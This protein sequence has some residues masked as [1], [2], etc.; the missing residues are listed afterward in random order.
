MPMNVSDGWPANWKQGQK[1]MQEYQK[2]GGIYNAFNDF[3][4]KDTPQ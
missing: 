2:T 1:D 3:L 4:G